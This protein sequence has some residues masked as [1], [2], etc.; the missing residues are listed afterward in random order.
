MRRIVIEFS[1]FVAAAILAVVLLPLII[2]TL[3]WDYFHKKEEKPEVM[4]DDELDETRWEDDLDET[5]WE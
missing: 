1:V 2:P 3:I 5:R 4:E